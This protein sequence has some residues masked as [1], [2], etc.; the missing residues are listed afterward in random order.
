MLKKL[1]YLKT[2]KKNK[3]LKFCCCA[4]VT[5]RAKVTHRVVLT[6][7]SFCRCAILTRSQ[8]YVICKTKINIGTKVCCCK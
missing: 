2:L 8:H 1:F 5:L 7:V 3:A 4:K 6:T